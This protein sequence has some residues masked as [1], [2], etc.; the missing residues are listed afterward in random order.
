M[1]TI[2]KNEGF[3][4]IN[5]YHSMAHRLSFQVLAEGTMTKEEQRDT[6]TQA[7]A[8]Q[9]KKDMKEPRWVQAVL[10]SCHLLHGNGAPSQRTSAIKPRP[11]VEGQ[12]T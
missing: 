6:L 7:A 1:L 10:P 11:D 3:A 4:C 12:I 8:V 2:L 9:A 5:S